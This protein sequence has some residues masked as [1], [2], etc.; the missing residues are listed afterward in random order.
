MKEEEKKGACKVT[1][2][3]RGLMMWGQRS[4]V[5][6]WEEIRVSKASRKPILFGRT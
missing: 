1:E 2:T 5:R 6:E 3:G 4:V